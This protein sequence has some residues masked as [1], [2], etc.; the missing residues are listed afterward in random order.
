MFQKKLISIIIPCY[1]EEKNINRTLDT[2]LELSRNHNFDFEFIA[3]ND[4]S[5]DNTW[6]VIKEYTD[7]HS[8]VVGINLMTNFGQS[9]AY[10]AG[11]D[12]SKGDYVVTVSA[13]LEIPLENVNKIIEYLERGYDFVNTNR[14]GRWG[15]EKAERAQKSQKAN[16]I[17]G[18]ISGVSMHD[19]GSGMKGFTRVLV[20]NLRLYGEMHRFIPDYLTVYGAKMI[21]FDVEFKDRDFGESAYKGHKRTIKVLLDLLTLAFLLYFAKKPFSSMPGRLFSFT[22][23]I[24]TGFGG[25]IGIYLAIL[26]LLGYSIGN[27]PLLILSVVMIIVGIQSMMMGMLGE[28][29][30]RVYFEASNRKT[31]IIRSISKR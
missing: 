12:A 30:L 18:R 27:R 28:L 22:G 19:R 15:S 8:N 9:A 23:A 3:V 6:K 13:D 29:M 25:L 17:I 1:N 10:Q 14:V 11:F 26:K 2:V 31:Y 7:K 20:D 21:E 5:K 16:E 24:I 4:G